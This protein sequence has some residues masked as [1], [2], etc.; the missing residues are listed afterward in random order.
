[1]PATH[2]DENSE[3]QLVARHAGARVLLAEDNPIN[4]EIARD[5]LE[6]AGLVVDVAQDGA[7]ALDMA[8]RT[9]YALVLMD[10]QMPNMNGLDA[11]RAIR[12]LPAYAAHRSWG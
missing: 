2:A 5:M 10:V 7:I 9:P 11:A 8:R 4:S 6:G 12:R 1:M 3:A